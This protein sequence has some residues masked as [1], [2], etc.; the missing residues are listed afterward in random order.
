M[1]SI[2]LLLR[3]WQIAQLGARDLCPHKNWQL[4]LL[5][6]WTLLNLMVVYISLLLPQNDIEKTSTVLLGTASLMLV[7]F[8]IVIMYYFLM[9]TGLTRKMTNCLGTFSESRYMKLSLY[10]ISDFF[11]VTA[12]KKCTMPL[13]PVDKFNETC[14]QYREP[15]LEDY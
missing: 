10:K 3:K 1:G 11:V 4:G 15:L 7:T 14:D 2:I 9:V 6:N 5:D 12:R 8:I 13:D